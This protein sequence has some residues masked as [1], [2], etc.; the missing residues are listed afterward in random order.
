M[1]ART[2]LV[3]NTLEEFR[4][5]F[6]SLSS[7]DIG[8]PAS[9]TTTA[10]SIVGAINEVNTTVTTAFK[11]ADDSSTQQTINSG[12]VLRFSSDSNTT[13]TVTATDTL[14]IGLAS[15][16]S[17][18]TSVSATT[19]TDGTMSINAGSLTSVVNV[20]GSGTAN[21]TTDVQVNSISVA[22][23]PFAI[24]QAVALG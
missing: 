20:T 4:T 18:L 7:T 2:V 15:S 16:I 12:D 3:T 10:T 1:T 9:L 6:N 19:I 24:A 23:Q 14:T 11:I 17:G 21:F 22:T 8:D 13:A 5:T